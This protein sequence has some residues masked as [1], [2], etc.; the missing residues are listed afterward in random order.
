MAPTTRAQGRQGGKRKTLLE[1]QQPKATRKRRRT[2][3]NNK[4][5]NNAAG[6]TNATAAIEKARQILALYLKFLTKEPRAK[7]HTK[8]L[9]ILQKHPLLASEPC[10]EIARGTPPLHLLVQNGASLRTIKAVVSLY[11]AALS[12]RSES[13]HLPLHIACEGASSASVGAAAGVIEFLAKEYPQAVVESTHPGSLPLHLLLVRGNNIQNNTS[14]KLTTIKVLV[15]MC[16]QAVA[17][18][19]ENGWNALA[20]AM[21]GRCEDEDE[22]ADILNYLAEQLAAQPSIP[23]IFTIPRSAELTLH[24]A[25]TL[26]HI[27]PRITKLQVLCRQ[28]TKDGMVALFQVLKSHGNLSHLTA[29]FPRS[30]LT[31]LAG[32]RRIER[33]HRAFLKDNTALEYLCYQGG[34]YQV[35]DK[36]NDDALLQSLLLMPRKLPANNQH[37]RNL[38]HFQLANCRFSKSNDISFLLSDYSMPAQVTFRNICIEGANWTNPNRMP[39]LSIQDLAFYNVQMSHTA[40]DTFG[41]E[42]RRMRNLKRLTMALPFAGDRANIRIT[43]VT[44]SLLSQGLEYLHVSY[45]IKLDIVKLCQE[46]L[47]LSTCPLKELHVPH[48]FASVETRKALAETLEH[49]NN[50]LLYVTLDKRDQYCP[51]ARWIRLLTHLNRLGRGRI[52]QVEFTADQLFR[53]LLVA[54][55]KEVNDERG[56]PITKDIDPNKL[57]NLTY[58]LLHESPSLWAASSSSG[59]G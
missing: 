6:S 52:R 33:A 26:E 18:V 45:D 9:K 37:P 27:L 20:C 29:T 16:P 50:T 34:W 40:C 15:E 47:I 46:S 7:H 36:T 35:G 32:L 21:V 57:L 22:K 54:N 30:L 10:N 43:T 28:A 24:A 13:G 11:P 39:P 42:L 12:A 4:A 51:H 23:N 48:A 59:A 31:P 25:Q 17:V 55:G 3:D 56:P 8:I 38:K 19:N 2:G 49:H 5:S 41:S 53:L 14:L 44:Q 1:Q 58:T